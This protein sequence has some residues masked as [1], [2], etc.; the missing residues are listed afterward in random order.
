MF[1]LV[2]ELALF[3]GLLW[4]I[5]SW[6]RKANSNWLLQKQKDLE[7]LE[8]EYGTVREMKGKFKNVEQKRKQV[9]E[10]KGE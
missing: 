2:M 9:S 4:A 3:L 6:A 10:F 7:D 5:V 8:R 1:Q